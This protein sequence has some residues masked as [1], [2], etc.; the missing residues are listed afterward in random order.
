MRNYEGQKL[1]KLLIPLQSPLQDNNAPEEVR[2]TK[3][4]TIWEVDIVSPF[5]ILHFSFELLF[6]PLHRKRIVFYLFRPTNNSYS[7]SEDFNRKRIKLYT[8]NADIARTTVSNI[9]SIPRKST[10]ITLTTFFPL[11]SKYAFSP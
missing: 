5:V 9:V 8:P 6:C 2:R 4:A 11:A 10:K 3:I 7:F 1:L